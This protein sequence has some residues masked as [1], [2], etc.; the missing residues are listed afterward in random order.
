MREF[1]RNA[2]HPD[3]DLIQLALERAGYHPGKI[4]GIFGRRTVDALNNFRKDRSMAQSEHIGAEDWA[5][6]APFL[7]GYIRRSIQVGDT[8]HRL[9]GEFRTSIEAIRTANPDIHPENL[10][11]GEMLTI[12][13][14]FDLVPTQIR[15]TST[16]LYYVIRGLTAR[17]PKIQR[18]TIGQSVGG[19]EISVLRFGAGSH[20][21]SFNAS[22]HGNEWITTPVL[23][24]FLEDYAK[25]EANNKQLA[26]QEANLLYAMSTLHLIPMVNPDGVGFIKNLVRGNPYVSMVSALGV[27]VSVIIGFNHNILLIN[28]FDGVEQWEKI[29]K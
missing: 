24:K 23:L 5:A 12:P 9:A 18:E 4:D 8:F 11:V 19:R 16:A 1:K 17:Y 28:I 10:K 7:T 20:Q 15:F 25:A 22:H 26:G 14:G 21:V 3:I 29:R 2:K 27:F 13:L 6:L